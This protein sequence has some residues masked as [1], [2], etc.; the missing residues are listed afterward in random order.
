MNWA[1]RYYKDR[2]FHGASHIDPP[3]SKGIVIRAPET[4][5][6]LRNHVAGE[7]A[8][9]VPVAYKETL[10]DVGRLAVWQ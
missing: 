2:V 8:K 3:G 7:Q 4:A 6:Q 9:A 5:K 10:E 1:A